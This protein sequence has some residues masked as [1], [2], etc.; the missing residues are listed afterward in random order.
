MSQTLTI[1]NNT[2]APFFLSNGDA[3]LIGQ[4]SGA[5]CTQPTPGAGVLIS[6]TCSIPTTA[7]SS[8]TLTLYSLPPAQGLGI[9]LATMTFANG[10][11]QTVTGPLKDFITTQISTNNIN[12]SVNKK[13]LQ[14]INNSNYTFSGMI[15]DEI[16]RTN[17]NL[18]AQSTYKNPLNSSIYLSLKSTTNSYVFPIYLSF[19]PYA[20]YIA[21]CGVDPNNSQPCDTCGCSIQAAQCQD[22]CNSCSAKNSCLQDCF[23]KA[24]S[25]IG[26]PS[27]PQKYS[28]CISACTNACQGNS[29]YSTCLGN[30]QNSENIC[31][32]NCPSIQATTSTNNGLTTCTITIS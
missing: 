5:S 9:N 29:Q 20:F 6:G 18:K 16:T 3:F 7:S 14:I 31:M 13:T 2:N 10:S 28:Q 1:T 12:I 15:D 4:P 21:N 24:A 11:L 23:A 30:C 19:D 22:N 26:D 17:F 25:C 8:F 27:C 32:K